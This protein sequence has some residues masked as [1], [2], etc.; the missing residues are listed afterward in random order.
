MELSVSMLKYYLPPNKRIRLNLYVVYLVPLIT[1]LITKSIFYLYW[2]KSPFHYYHT[3]IGLDMRK[4]LIHGE[5]FYHGT[6][7]F[8]PYRLLIGLIFGFFGSDILPECVVMVQLVMG[9]ITILLTVYVA[10]SISGQKHTALLAGMFMALYAPVMVYE[11][12]ILK[13]S[14]FLFISLLSLAS[15]LYAR[16]RKF[17]PFPLFIAGVIAIL[18]LFIRHAGFFWL[19]TSFCWL[20]FYCRIRVIKECGI[21]FMDL[22]TTYPR[23]KPLLFFLA[24]SLTFLLIVAVYNKSNGF[25]S[26]SYFK[27]NYSYLLAVG[28]D[29]NDAISQNTNSPDKEKIPPPSVTVSKAIGKVQHYA[30]KVFSLFNIF[31]LPNNINYYFIQKKL[32]ILKFFI[33]PALLIPLALTGLILMIVNGGFHRKE[34]LLFFYTASFAIPICLFL[35]LGRYKLVLS[36]VFCIAAAYCLIYIAKIVNRKN[37]TMNNILTPGILAVIF[38]FTISTT[39]YPERISDD[40]TYGIAVSYVPDKLMHKGKFSEASLILADY[41]AENQNNPMI[42]LNYASALLGCKRPKDT[43]YILTKLGVPENKELAGRY[44]YELGETYRML[45]E[46]EK[47][48]KCYHEVLKYP[49]A[50][51]RKVLAKKQIE[52]LF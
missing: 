19:L 41:Y 6:E 38:F 3:I 30:K 8:S 34:S 47:A 4:F 5:N 20:A 7:P 44:Y 17:A 36:P 45:H 51:H 1:G 13:A 25:D 23:F 49:C 12:Q 29:E 24:G 43:K 40:N 21:C 28:A 33:G 9:I 2:F 32:P 35:P 27:P 48:L 52:N 42:S 26:L 37:N 15:L 22:R 18:P 16:K 14:L 31:E 46:K 11:T 10:L 39:L 50:E